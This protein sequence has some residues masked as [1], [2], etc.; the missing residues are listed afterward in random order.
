MRACIFGLGEKSQRARVQPRLIAMIIKSSP[1][2]RSANADR[3][4]ER[5][6][7]AEQAIY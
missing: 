4:Q 2:V 7:A 3:K 1:A 5:A 6:P